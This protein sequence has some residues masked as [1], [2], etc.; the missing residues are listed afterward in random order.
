M[1]KEKQ[2]QHWHFCSRLNDTILADKT[3]MYTIEFIYFQLT[4][5]HVCIERMSARTLAVDS[6]CHCK[7]KKKENP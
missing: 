5:Q 4:P 2:T 3:Y 7:K 1:T 6:F